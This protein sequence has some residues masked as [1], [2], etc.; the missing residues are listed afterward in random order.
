M[1]EGKNIGITKTTFV[2]GIIVAILVSS[3]IS[4]FA[5]SQLNLSTQS[6]Q[7][8]GLKGD[9][10]DTGATGPQ[11]PKGDTGATGPAGPQGPSGNIPVALSANLDSSM[12]D[13][14]QKTIVTFT[15]FI[16]NFGTTTAN[17]VV[18]RFTFIINEGQFIK[19][20]NLPSSIGGQSVR[21]LWIQFPFDFQF[22]SY[23]VNWVITWT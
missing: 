12:M 1:A 16:I 6:S 23:N 17:N 19:T 3:L 4:V 18:I 5:V 21:S 9:K 13:V 11:G 22:S 10:G 7:V 20:Y 2:I 8:N 14:N 15:G